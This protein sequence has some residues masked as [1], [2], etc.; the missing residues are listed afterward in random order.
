M[1]DLNKE[2]EVNLRFEQDD[3]FVWVFDGDSQFG[4]EISHLMMMHADE[5]NEDELR[6]ICNHA[7]CEIDKL[8]A[9]LEKAKAQAVPTW[10]SVKDEEPPTDTMVLICWSDAPDVTPEQDYMTIDEDLN[11]VWANYQNDPPS[12]WMHFHSV[13]NVSGAEQ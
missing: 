7:A 5:Y 3:G 13:P 6:V 12:H 8:R 2:R 11:S 1:T 9:E 10:I 4:T